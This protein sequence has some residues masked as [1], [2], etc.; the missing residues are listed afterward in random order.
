M[1][2]PVRR[3]ER[4]VLAAMAAGWML[5]SHRDLDGAKT[6]RLHALSGAER[7]VSPSVVEKLVAQGLIQSNQKFPVATYLLTER[8]RR[9]AQS[10]HA[11][12]QNAAP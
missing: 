7:P 10:H 12:G 4:Q 11:S 9:A 1:P 6:Y 2:W 5:R 3:E 8:G